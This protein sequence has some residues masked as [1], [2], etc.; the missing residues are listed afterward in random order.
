VLVDTWGGVF[1]PCT[2]YGRAEA[3][4]HEHIELGVKNV[5][6]VGASNTS[7]SHVAD[8]IQ[9]DA[10]AICHANTSALEA[11]HHPSPTSCRG[12]ARVTRT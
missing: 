10:V 7:A 8:L 4:R 12:R 2:P 1:P 9:R 11:I 6:V 3:A 5:P